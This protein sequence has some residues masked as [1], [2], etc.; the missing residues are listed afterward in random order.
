M[1]EVEKV[2]EEDEKLMVKTVE[3]EAEKEHLKTAT[4]AEDIRTMALEDCLCRLSASGKK[5]S[6]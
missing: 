4:D 6:I 3:E 2:Y 1:K 5:S